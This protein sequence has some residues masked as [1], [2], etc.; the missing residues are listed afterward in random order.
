MRCGRTF[1]AGAA[2]LLLCASPLRAQSPSDQFVTT[3][4]PAPGAGPQVR[5]F[6]QSGPSPF[7]MLLRSAD[8]S[9]AQQTQVQQ[10]LQ[11]QGEQNRTL[12]QQLQT[13]E[14]EISAKLLAVGT[15]T[16]ADL[17]PLEQQAAQIKQ[18]MDQN[19][20]D[21]SLAIRNILSADQ[22][23]HLA[24]V[25]QQLDSLRAQIEKLIGPGP[26]GPGGPVVMPPG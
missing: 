8:L 17:A 23:S 4:G 14:T 19:M 20:I 9:S 11:S 7:M 12:V 13:V 15:V 22:L 18:Q 25:H 24:Q 5:V 21:T 2:M 26:G 10:V 1:A 16:A 6:V 3:G